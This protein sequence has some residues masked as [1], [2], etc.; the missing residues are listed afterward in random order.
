MRF[1]LTK[2]RPLELLNF[3]AFGVAFAAAK[4]LIAQLARASNASILRLARSR[5]ALCFARGGRVDRKQRRRAICSALRTQ[6]E[7]RLC[8]IS[9][10]LASTPS[11]PQVKMA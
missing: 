2:G 6:S 4:H 11:L 9:A 5:V 1:N 3:S 10:A 7:A 8:Y